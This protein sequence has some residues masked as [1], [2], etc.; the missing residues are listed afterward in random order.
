MFRLSPVKTSLFNNFRLPLISTRL[1]SVQSIQLYSTIKRQSPPSSPCP[2]IKKQHHIGIP[3][4]LTRQFNKSSLLNIYHK[5]PRSRVSTSSSILTDILSK[6]PDSLKIIIGLSVI[7]SIILFVALPLIVVVFPPLLIGSFITYKLYQR[8]HKSQMNF[9]WK[10]LKT[11]KLYFKPH[12]TTSL[13]PPPEQINNELATFELERL[14][15][16]FF[17]NEFGISDYFQIK[18]YN[19]LALGSIDAMEYDWNTSLT[20]SNELLT[21]QSRALYDKLSGDKL[22]TVVLSL[23][24]SDQI[25]IFQ[26]LI[27][28][29]LG[30]INNKS[31]CIIEIIPIGFTSKKKF[32]IK[33]P[34]NVTNDDG[35]SFIEIKGKTRTL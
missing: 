7:S 35:D 5:P 30:M 32:I 12:N 29:D 26:D 22:A 8:R 10:E 11:S 17:S 33:T 4:I 24:S 19:Q 3:T 18:D 2:T 34:S 21:V 16:A 6:I 14:L 13:I 23:K 27:E 9:R 20:T 15:D 1:S 28:Q 25:P 31:T